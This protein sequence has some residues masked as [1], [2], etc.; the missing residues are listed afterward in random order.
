MTFLSFQYYDTELY[1]SIKEQKNFEKSVFT[2]S[3]KADSMYPLDI[4]LIYFTQPYSDELW[5]LCTLCV[6]PRYVA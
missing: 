5:N 6:K 3:H 2:K 4:V 1:P